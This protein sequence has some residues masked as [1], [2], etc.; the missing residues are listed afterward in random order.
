MMDVAGL[1]LPQKCAFLLDYSITTQ[2]TV[3]EYLLN[4]WL[5]RLSQIVHIGL[6]L[7]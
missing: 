5:G 1:H 4:V 6:M 2:K 3:D 7:A